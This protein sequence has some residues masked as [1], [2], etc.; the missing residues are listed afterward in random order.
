[1]DRSREQKEQAYEAAR[2]RLN[3]ASPSANSSGHMG[4]MANPF[5]MTS[6][7]VDASGK[8]IYRNR[9]EDLRDPDYQ[10]SARYSKTETGIVFP[11][12]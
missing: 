9:H 7:G 3:L 8:A 5:S 12:D 11:W 1:M 6:Q 10:R 2:Q 4:M